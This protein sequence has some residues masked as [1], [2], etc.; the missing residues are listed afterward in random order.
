MFELI[1]G[2]VQFM[3]VKSGIV[4][5]EYTC[6][7]DHTFDFIDNLSYKFLEHHMYKNHVI[8]GNLT[9][10]KCTNPISNVLDKTGKETTCIECEVIQYIGYNYINVWL[11][12]D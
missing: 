6:D 3:P 10:P 7:C 1:E 4:V 8:D 2:K 12:Q 5:Q 9:C 11:Y